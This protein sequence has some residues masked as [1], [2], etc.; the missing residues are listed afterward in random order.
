MM[1]AWTFIV[2][3]HKSLCP[4]PCKFPVY[5]FLFFKAPGIWVEEEGGITGYEGREQLCTSK[6]GSPF[7]LNF[8]WLPT[9]AQLLNL[10]CFS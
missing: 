4:S 8:E 5:S 3:S 6:Q 7:T 1:V 2:N 9:W 10:S